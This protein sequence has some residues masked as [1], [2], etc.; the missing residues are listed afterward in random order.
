MEVNTRVAASPVIPI[1]SR[2]ERP[3]ANELHAADGL[4]DLLEDLPR[5]G[6]EVG[7][8]RCKPGETMALP[9]EQ[10]YAYLLFKPRYLFGQRRLR[11]LQPTGGT[12][13]I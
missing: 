1:R 2:P 8:R 10:A 11:D 12:T 6:K 5:L 9:C 7:A 3:W 13:E 4:L